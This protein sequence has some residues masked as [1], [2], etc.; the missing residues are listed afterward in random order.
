MIYTLMIGKDVRKATVPNIDG[1]FGGNPCKLA[2]GKTLTIRTDKDKKMDK[3]KMDNYRPEEGTEEFRCDAPLLCL[4]QKDAIGEKYEKT[5]CAA[6][7]LEWGSWTACN[8]IC[9]D[10]SIMKRERHRKCVD[11]CNRDKSADKSKCTPINATMHNPPQVI[12]TTETTDCVPCPVDQSPSWAEWSEWSNDGADKPCGEGKFTQVRKRECSR[13]KNKAAKCKNEGKDEGGATEKREFDKAPCEKASSYTS[14]PAEEKDQGSEGEQGEGNDQG[15]QG[16]DD[17]GGDNQG[18]DEQ[19]G[20]DQGGD[21]QGEGEQEGDDQGGDNQGDEQE[22]DD[23]GGDNQ[24]DEQ[25]GD[26]QGGDNQGDEQEGDDQGGD[27]QG[28]NE[29]EGDDQGGDN[30]GDEQ[31][32]DDQGGDN[33][34]EEEQ[35]QPEA[36]GF[37]EGYEE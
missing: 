9:G 1:L 21:N 16:G 3:K 18:G 11:M 8:D 20:N 14:E 37:L 29:Q 13:A 26:D 2:N 7:W 33:Q 31:E 23:Q 17:Q 6:I 5:F 25:E 12:T 34:G 27:N 15:N 19:E 35:E 32:G 30:Q 22:G 10:R 24:G 36:E 28:E 4:V